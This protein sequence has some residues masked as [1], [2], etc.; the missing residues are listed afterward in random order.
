MTKYQFIKKLAKR[1]NITY[2]E[3][4]WVVN[5]FLDEVADVLKNGDSVNFV[6]FGKF[7][8]R[9]KSARNGRNPKTNETILIP[10][11]R[12][13]ALKQGKGLKD[14]INGTVSKI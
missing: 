9:E 7:C 4:A 5:A 13:A 8:V 12:Y 14:L 3:S 2:R 1:A 10:A 11:S 6:G